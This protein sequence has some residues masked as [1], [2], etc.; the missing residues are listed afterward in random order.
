MFHSVHTRRCASFWATRAARGAAR[1]KR[2][3]AR[4]CNNSPVVGMVLAAREAGLP[5]WIDFPLTVARGMAAV[6]T[7]RGCCVRQ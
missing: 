3:V 6:D 2:G 1:A 7:S 4:A 5:L